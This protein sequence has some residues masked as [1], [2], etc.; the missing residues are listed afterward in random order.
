[1]GLIRSGG[2][3]VQHGRGKEASAWTKK[4]KRLAYVSANGPTAGD[5]AAIGPGGAGDGGAGGGR[6]GRVAASKRANRDGRAPLPTTNIRM[7]STERR[8]EW[9][10]VASDL[11]A[12]P[13]FT[14]EARLMLQN[15]LGANGGHLPQRKLV[16]A[17]RP[18]NSP[19]H[20]LFFW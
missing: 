2:Y 1:M 5:E 6:L 10:R 14:E 15:I 17:A 13:E 8:R 16:E 9:R 19:L 18:L 11:W 3:G 4:R 12:G 7:L 20:S